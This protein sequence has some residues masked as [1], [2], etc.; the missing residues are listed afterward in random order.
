MSK[1][2][3]QKTSYALVAIFSLGLGGLAIAAPHHEG[4]GD[5]MKE[6]DTNGDGQISP[7]EFQAKRDENFA[8]FD[9]DG[10]PGLSEAEFMAMSEHRAEQHRERRAK[11]MFNKLDANGDGVVDTA[12]LAAKSD[13]MFGK[14]DSNDDGALSMEEMKDGKMARHHGPQ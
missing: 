3:I 13:K 11:Y 4:G 5:R 10:T 1:I 2:S 8:M 9:V 14:L 6:A 7:Q 12:E